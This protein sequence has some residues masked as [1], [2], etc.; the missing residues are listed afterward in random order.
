[1]AACGGPQVPEHNGY[2]VKQPWKKAKQ[3]KLDDKGE[4]KLEG[5]LSYPAQKRA[6]WYSID[7][8]V[9]GQ[10]D[11]KLEITPPGDAVN[12]DFDLGFQVLDP[13][14]R[15]IAKSDLE[16]GGDA[17]E[18]SKSK[19]LVDLMPGHYFVHLY[20]Q[21]RLDTCEYVLRVAFKAAPPAEIKNDFPSQVQFVGPLAQVPLTDDTPKTYKPPVVATK[22]VK[23][24]HTQPV[25]PKDPPPPVAPTTLEARIIGMNVNG[26]GTQIV[27]SRGTTSGA[28]A[29]MAG[30]VVG[31]PSSGF[32]LEGCTDRTCTA[33]LKIGPDVIKGAS[34]VV[35]SASP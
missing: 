2:K 10:L 30:Q 20:L 31:V 3:V 17:K 23:P 32:T 35:L 15:S 25:K 33:T 7:L 28:K 19:S 11:F 24:T 26:G 12:E 27:V 1:M 18:L 13:H 8:P 16:D 14:N 5:D 21:S 34:K 22:P 4:A 9:G 29:G 6:A